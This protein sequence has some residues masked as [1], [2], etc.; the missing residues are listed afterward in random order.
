MQRKG[1]TLVEIMV[2]V[3]LISLL[4]SFIVPRILQ[5]RLAK[6]EQAAIANLKKIIAPALENYAKDNNGAYPASEQNLTQG[7]PPYLNNAYNEKIIQGYAYAFNL[8]ES[9]YI[10]E[11]RPYKCGPHGTARKVYT[12]STGAV[13]NESDCPATSVE[14]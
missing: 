8:T 1:F 7:K 14:K 5:M 10:V 4:A 9:G 6:N 2:A 11:A 3:A 13:F 12:V